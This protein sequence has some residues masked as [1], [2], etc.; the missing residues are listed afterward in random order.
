[1]ENISIPYNLDRGQ[2]I[3]WGLFFSFCDWHR[4]KN[5]LCK[6]VKAVNETGVVSYFTPP[7]SNSLCYLIPCDPARLMIVP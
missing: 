1:M 2:L 7:V 4:S 6:N 5:G 3:G